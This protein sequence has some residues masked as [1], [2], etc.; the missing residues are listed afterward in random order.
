MALSI[1][2]IPWDGPTGSVLIGMVDG[3]FIV[4]PSLAQ[5]EES[6]MHLVV[7]GTKDAIMM[8]EAGANEVPEETILDAIMFAHEEIKKIVEFIE[9]IVKE[10]GKPKMEVELYKVPEDIEKAV[11]DYAED[12]MR[13]AI[14]TYDKM[15]RLDNMDAVEAR[16]RT[17]FEEIYPDNA[18]DIGNVLYAITKEQ[19]RSLILDD[20]IRPDNRKRT[21]IRPIWCETG[22]LPRTH[23]SGLFK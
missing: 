17:H 6:C 23:G 3:Q 16:R 21:E 11:R 9:E 18:K 8:V 15:E 7:S 12:K 20:E 22:L 19:V 14:Q 4:N 2:D 5:R 13:A 10:V 1:S